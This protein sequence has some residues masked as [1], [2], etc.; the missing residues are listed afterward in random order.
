MLHLGPNRLWCGRW[1]SDSDSEGSG[2]GSRATKKLHRLFRLVNYT[3]LHIWTILQLSYSYLPPAAIW[4]CARQK[5]GGATA[6]GTLPQRVLQRGVSTSRSTVSA[7]CTQE[8]HYSPVKPE[9]HQPTSQYTDPFIRPVS[10]RSSA[11][12]VTQSLCLLLRLPTGRLRHQLSAPQ[13]DHYSLVKLESHQPTSQ[14]TDSFI[15]PVSTST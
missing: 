7:A 8:D 15:R 3:R 13:E 14:C 2:S 5:F 10:T 11:I 6:S 1:H 4:R 9:P 12:R